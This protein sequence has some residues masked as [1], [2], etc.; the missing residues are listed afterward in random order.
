MSARI[1]VVDDI[2]ANVRLL[3]AKLTA[4][5]FDVISANDGP[6]ALQLAE[7]E[8]PDLILTDIMMPGMDGFEVCERLKA[9][10]ATRHIPVVMIT[11]LS[12]VSDRVRGL[13]AGADDFLTKPVNDIALF[14]RVRSLAR[15]KLTMDEL[16]IRRAAASQSEVVA[17][18]AMNE[19]TGSCARILLA[20]ASNLNAERLRDSLESDG[21]KV[22]IEASIDGAIS[23]ARQD[24]FDLLI[25]N[26]HIGNEDGLRLCSQFRSH[27]A[28][29]NTPILL[30]LDEDELPRL[31]KGMDLGVTDYLIKPV[32]R[33]ELQ[34]RCRTQVKRRRYHDQLRQV[35][36][37][38]VSMAYIDPLTSVYNRRY[39]N[40]HLERKI[41]EIAETTKPV[42][43]LLFDI[44]HFK[45]VNDHYGHAA[46]DKVLQCLT[47]RAQICLRDLDMVARY[48]GEEFVIVMPDSDQRV[49]IKVAER[50][51][52]IIAGSTFP[53]STSKDDL[54]VTISIGCATTLDPMETSES[55]LRRAD[56]ALY[57]AK[58]NGR[59]CV[60]SSERGKIE[61]PRVALAQ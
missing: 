25:A 54:Q 2:P 10:A 55:L 11:A 18:Q 8:S 57:E 42:S 12:D 17:D 28:T 16:R 4:E 15:L 9:N 35:L 31:A 40:A 6:S 37:T 20:E 56:M 33:N 60:V 1:L 5:Y 14:A 45:A 58:A 44:D 49:A 47:K 13:E 36:R 41:M 27:E 19:I 48:G 30:V 32:D 34:A 3:E 51:R 39:M 26:L 43:V 53:V 50:L 24:D 21:H 23:A 52:Q 29:R 7:H 59:N 46:G 22:R 61:T 38:S